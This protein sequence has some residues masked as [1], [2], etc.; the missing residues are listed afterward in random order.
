MQCHTGASVKPGQ[1]SSNQLHVHNPTAK[2]LT[3]ITIGIGHLIEPAR[4]AD[5]VALQ[6]RAP[7]CRSSIEHRSRGGAGSRA[8]DLKAK[9][10][11]PGTHGHVVA[12]LAS[13]PVV[14]EDV[15]QQ[16]ALLDGIIKLAALDHALIRTVVPVDGLPEGVRGRQHSKEQWGSGRGIQCGGCLGLI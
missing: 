10:L 5:V 7:P 14:L 1:G 11:A 8:H 2:R 13:E 4:N 12:L 6:Q 15:A 16:A 9:E 3:A